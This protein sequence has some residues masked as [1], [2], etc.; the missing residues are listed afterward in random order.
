MHILFVNSCIRG[1]QS[2]TLRLCRTALD[3]M[4][5][6]LSDVTVEE[7][8]LDKEEVLPLN[9]KRLMERHELEEKEEFN[10]PMFRYAKQF[11]AADVILVGV[12]YWEYQFPAMF[13]CYLEQVS[14]CGVTFAYTEDGRPKGLCQADRLLYVT[15][16]G[17]PILHRNCGFDYVKTLCGDMLGIAN[18][19]FAAAEGLDVWGTDVEAKLAETEETLRT[20][21]RSWK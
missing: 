16:S 14:V 11:A 13:R 4:Q 5:K 9:S 3:E 12:P 7:L 1:E 18:M 17:G 2:R 20:M 19:E 15:T 6:T 10:N 8:C 21:I